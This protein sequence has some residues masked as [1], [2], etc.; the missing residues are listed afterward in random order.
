MLIR[1]PAMTK[2]TWLV[3]AVAMTPATTKRAKTAKP[4]VLYWPNLL[5]GY[6][7]FRPA[8]DW[9]SRSESINSWRVNPPAPA[10]ETKFT[11]E[12]RENT[13][14]LGFG[15]LDVKSKLRLAPSFCAFE[16]F[17]VGE[18]WNVAKAFARGECL[19]RIQNELGAAG[20]LL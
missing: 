10:R 5:M 1:M 3:S 8:S 18:C 16:L 15:L 7:L 9:N 2:V 17:V 13:L 20:G 19:N 12:L 11:G 14:A 4:T 6:L